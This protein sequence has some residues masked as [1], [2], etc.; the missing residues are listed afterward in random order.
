MIK[1]IRP[2][3][4]LSILAAIICIARAGSA[5]AFDTNSENLSS[6]DAT[7]GFTDPDDQIAPG[8]LQVAPDLQ[9]Y[10]ETYNQLTPDQS[11]WLFSIA[12]QR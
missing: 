5:V 7:A 10:K 1:I 2:C 11:G 4:G 3:L 9:D 8:L 12:P 6:S